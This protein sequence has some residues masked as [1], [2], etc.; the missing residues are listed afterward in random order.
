MKSES[1]M[2]NATLPHFRST[3]SAVLE[4]SPFLHQYQSLT[5]SLV[6]LGTI[7]IR[8]CP[9]ATYSVIDRHN[10]LLYISL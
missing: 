7:L 6:C 2:A 4:Q 9:F 3:P 10:T 5:V 8:L 1:D